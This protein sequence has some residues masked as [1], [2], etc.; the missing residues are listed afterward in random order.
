MCHFVCLFISSIG[1]ALKEQNLVQDAIA[2]YKSAIKLRP[3][4]AIAHG[5]LGS[6]YYD[7]G[8]YAAAIKSFNYAIQLEPNYPDAYNNL[9]NIIMI[10]IPGDTAVDQLRIGIDIRS[11][12]LPC[13]IY[14]HMLCLDTK[15]NALKEE[16]RIDEAI[17][18]YRAALHLKADHPHAYNNL[19]GTS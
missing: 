9:G 19:G 8:D 1:N 18:A 12:A 3:D 2:S 13:V 10:T 7:I 11:T 15:G 16:S 5:N 6:C 4:F 14:I 17:N